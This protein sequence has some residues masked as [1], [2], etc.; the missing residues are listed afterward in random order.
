MRPQVQVPWGRGLRYDRKGVPK[1]PP[2]TN[3]HIERVPPALSTMQGGGCLASPPGCSSLGRGSSRPPGTDTLDRGTPK[4]QGPWKGHP[5]EPVTT[6]GVCPQHSALQKGGGGSPNPPE[7]A[8]GQGEA[9]RMFN[10]TPTFTFSPPP[11]L[12]RL[13]LRQRRAGPLRQ[14]RGAPPTHGSPR[15]VTCPPTPLHTPHLYSPKYL[16]KYLSI[17]TES[18]VL[19]LCWGGNRDNRT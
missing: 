15:P 18:S 2:R 11:G 1:P 12:R 13:R 9:L 10:T 14:R 3:Y 16:Y 19:C 17:S 4:H 6:G 8:V 7:P 5:P